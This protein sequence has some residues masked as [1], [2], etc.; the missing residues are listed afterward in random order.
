MKTTRCRPQND[1]AIITHAG[2]DEKSISPQWLINVSAT[3]PENDP[4]MVLAH[5]SREP[6]CFDEPSCGI[7]SC[8]ASPRCAPGRCGRRGRSHFASIAFIE[9]ALCRPFRHAGLAQSL[10]VAVCAH[11]AAEGMHV[12]HEGD[13]EVGSHP[14]QLGEIAPRLVF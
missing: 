2:I 3:T 11:I 13:R 9:L 6:T 10:I 7:G 8:D 5:T 14:R 12:A 4:V 1:A